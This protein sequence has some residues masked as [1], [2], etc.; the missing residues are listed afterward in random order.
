MGLVARDERPTLSF[1]GD[2]QP[3]VDHPRHD[4]GLP[5]RIAVAMVVGFSTGAPSTMGAAPAAW[6]P[7]MR[8]VEATTASCAYSQYPIQYAVMF[9]ALPTGMQWTSGARPR[10]S[11]ISN[12]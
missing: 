11:Q 8:G 4:A 2:V 12:A 3:G 10:A 6:K 1:D 9:P 5:M 7:N